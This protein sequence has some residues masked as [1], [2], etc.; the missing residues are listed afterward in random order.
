MQPATIDFVP[1]YET[2]RSMLFPN[3]AGVST[4]V[5]GFMVLALAKIVLMQHLAI[6][7]TFWMLTIGL[8]SI[9]V[10]TVCSLIPMKLASEKWAKEKCTLDWQARAIT[11]LSSYSTGVW[12]ICRFSSDHWID[13]PLWLADEPAEDR[14]SHRP[15]H[16]SCGPTIPITKIKPSSTKPLMPH[17]KI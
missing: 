6:V 12:Q 1:A 2:M 11:K 4:D 9:I 15:V 13:D 3:W 17:R 7:M 8:T 14:R 5:A 16:Q 10:P